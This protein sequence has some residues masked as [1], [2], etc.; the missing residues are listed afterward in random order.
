MSSGYKYIDVLRQSRQSQE[1]VFRLFYRKISRKSMDVWRMDKVRN[2]Y[3]RGSLKVA[4]VIEKLK[5]NRLSWYGHV[6]RRDETHVTKRVLSLHV[7]GWKGRERPKKR[8][9]D[10]VRSDIKEK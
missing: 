7:D 3:I 2:E 6:K 5:G 4:P 8:W 1:L 10:C 9:M